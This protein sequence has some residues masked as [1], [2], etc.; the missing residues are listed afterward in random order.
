MSTVKKVIFVSSTIIYSEYYPTSTLKE[1]EEYIN[2]EFSKKD[3]KCVYIRPTMIFGTKN[4]QNIS[5]FI[6]WILKYRVFPIVNHGSATIQ[7][8]SRLDLAKMYYA[9]LINFDSLSSNDYIVSG[10][11]SMTLLE[12][13]QTIAK[14]ANRNVR[15]F[16]VPF[17]FARFL[18]NAAYIMSFKRI[19]YKEP[20]DRLTEDRAYPHERITDELGYSPLTFEE[21]VKPLIEEIRNN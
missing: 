19:N 18:V 8:V 13:L 4:D 12:M 2:K 14:L 3:I 10:D 6:G 21:R 20:L 9:V 5:R 16:N 7:P 11:R 1:D 17:G 15:F